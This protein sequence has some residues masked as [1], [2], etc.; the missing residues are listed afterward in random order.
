MFLFVSWIDPYL[1]LFI[2]IVLVFGFVGIFP[3]GCEIC[4]SREKEGGG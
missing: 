1:Y 4:V 3:E 2:L